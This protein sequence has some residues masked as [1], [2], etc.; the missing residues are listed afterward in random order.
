MKTAVLFAVAALVAAAPA[1]GRAQS[2]RQPGPAASDEKTVLARRLVDASGGADQ[3][4]TILSTAF[5][6][7]SATIAGSLPP[8][9]KRF[10]A[11]II[12]KMQDHLIEMTPKMV[13]IMVQVYAENLT[14]DELRQQVAWVESEP[15]KAL[16]RKLPSIMQETFRLMTPMLRHFSEEMKVDIVEEACKEGKCTPLD[17]ERIE[18]AMAK[19]FPKQS[20]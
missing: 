4:N 8:E 17:R 5:K 11:I 6:S 14:D 9:E 7:T 20:S 12:Q 15:A 2:T 3:L 10:E 18:S 19:A 13:D 16:R 1:L